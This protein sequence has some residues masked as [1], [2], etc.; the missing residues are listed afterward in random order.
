MTANLFNDVNVE[1]LVHGWHEKYFGGAQAT[2]IC[3][4]QYS[5]RCNKRTS[6]CRVVINAGRILDKEAR[7]LFDFVQEGR[8]ISGRALQLTQDIIDQCEG[9]YTVW[10]YRRRLIKGLQI[11]PVQELLFIRKYT[12]DRPKNYQ[13][14]YFCEFPVLG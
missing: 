8:E 1:E 14:W 11:D 5:Q 12:N 2:E 13:L 6:N 3:P 7:A 9:H 10:Q 4:I